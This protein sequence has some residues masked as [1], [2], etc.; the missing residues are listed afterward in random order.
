MSPIYPLYFTFLEQA[1]RFE[2]QGSEGRQSV[3]RTRQGK[4]LFDW[5][6]L[7]TGRHVDPYLA[8]ANEACLNGD[9][10]ECF[11]SRALNTFSEFFDQPEYSL[12]ENVKVIRMPRDIVQDVNKQPYEYASTAR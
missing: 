6:G 8:R 11:K 1:P 9:F 4:D 2:N 5:I 7:G 3:N 10:A 12:S